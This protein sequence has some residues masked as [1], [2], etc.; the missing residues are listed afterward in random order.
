M[1]DPLP[2]WS[3]VSDRERRLALGQFAF[4]LAAVA[5]GLGGA[6][7]ILVFLSIQAPN[8]GLRRFVDDPRWDLFLGG[9]TLAA[10]LL[11]AL[12]LLGG[13]RIH[14]GWRIRSLLLVMV[15]AVGV[16]LWC[17]AH[18]HIFGGGDEAPPLGNDPLL[19]LILRLI[20]LIRIVTLAEMAEVVATEAGKQEFY[21][22]RSTAVRFAWIGFLL[23]FLVSVT[24]LHLRPLRWRNIRNFQTW[25][26][27]AFSILSRGLSFIFAAILCGHAS[28]SSRTQRQAQLKEVFPRSF[29]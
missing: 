29:E 21:L 26:M 16:G 5:T 3:Q 6:Y 10:N 17:M 24:H 9:P 8:L 19:V 4:A 15:C 22:L 28:A 2:D 13:A 7:Q 11:A 14:R 27:L 25:T 20:A 1:D 18:R 23:W 12:L